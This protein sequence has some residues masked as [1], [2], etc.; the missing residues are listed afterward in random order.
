M[1]KNRIFGVRHLEQMV[2]IRNEIF[3]KN[4]LFR[5]RLTSNLNVRPQAWGQA[6]SFPGSSGRIFV[7]TG[8]EEHAKLLG[9][10]QLTGLDSQVPIST[11]ETLESKT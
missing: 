7:R 4:G 8:T 2:P 9:T 5:Y 6:S 1:R 10:G 11:K 3:L